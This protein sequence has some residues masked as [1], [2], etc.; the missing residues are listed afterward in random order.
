MPETSLR[1]KRS[2]LWKARLWS[3][4]NR[5]RRWLWVKSKSSCFLGWLPPCSLLKRLFCVFVMEVLI[6]IGMAV[7]RFPWNW[8]EIGWFEAA[9]HE[10]KAF[11]VWDLYMGYVSNWKTFFFQQVKNNTNFVSKKTE[12]PWH[13]TSTNG[14]VTGLRVTGLP[15]PEIT[16][17]SQTWSKNSAEREANT[18]RAGAAFTA[19]S[20][21]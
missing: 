13:S 1:A 19:F 3:L 4:F 6:Q 17:W 20:Q 21:C 10:P 5:K 14:W 11:P 15:N 7:V 9:Q 18:W 12:K 8:W 16:R 2:R